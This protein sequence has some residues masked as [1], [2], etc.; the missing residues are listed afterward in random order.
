MASILSLLWADPDTGRTR[1]E[2]GLGDHEVKVYAFACPSTMDI[3]L[4]E[5]TEGMILTTVIGWDWLARVSHT[6]VLEIRDAALKLKEFEV[7]QPGILECII[8][9]ECTPEERAELFQ[10]RHQITQEHIPREND[11]EKIHPPG[12]IAWI[13]KSMEDPEKYSF[14]HVKDRS[15]VF[16]EI[17]FDDDMMKSHHPPSYDDILFKM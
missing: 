8:S 7:E 11:Y 6:S 16:G 9:G 17:L 10:L 15:K 5:R 14:Y 4:S 13:Y 3:R 1:P 12:R 2:S